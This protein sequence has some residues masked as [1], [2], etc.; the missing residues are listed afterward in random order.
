MFEEKDIKEVERMLDTNFDDGLTEK[1]AERRYRDGANELVEEEKKTVLEMFIEQLLDP[2]IYVL[3][4]A[5]VISAFLG[6]WQDTGIIFFVIFLNAIIG[7]IQEGKAEKALDS[8]RKL[9]SPLALVKREGRVYEIQ[10]AKLVPGDLVILETGKQV[11]ADIRL[12]KS[13]GVMTDE[14]ALTGESVP[15][16][17]D[18]GFVAQ[19]VMPVG[20]RKN[21]VFSSTYVVRG[22]A[23][24]SDIKK[25][26]RHE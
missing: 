25:E 12:T 2:L 17:K 3:M 14:S 20:D 7:C 9:T 23:E 4:G 15:V 8:L 10:A 11:P 22:R 26:N 21:T 24:G 5:G 19:K 6:E 1:E 18:A 13:V 16:K